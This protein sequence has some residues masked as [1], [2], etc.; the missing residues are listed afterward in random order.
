MLAK[1]L[2]MT[3]DI[4]ASKV[5]G[6][7]WVSVKSLKAKRRSE[8]TV[9]IELKFS[10]G[11]CCLINSPPNAPETCLSMRLLCNENIST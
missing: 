7:L 11:Q 3:H 4:L 1:A 10:T 6:G 5:E 8:L 9:K 2:K